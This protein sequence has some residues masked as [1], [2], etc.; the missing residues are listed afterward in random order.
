MAD[1]EIM[2]RQRILSALI[3]LPAFVLLVQLGSLFHFTLLVGLAIALGAWEFARLC[4]VGTDRG[5]AALSVLGALAWYA[6]TLWT[7][8]LAGLLALL[9]GVGLLRTL[10]IRAEIRVGVL[11]AAW[12][13]LGVAYVGGLLSFASLLRG[14]TDGRQLVTYLAF[15]IWAGD[16]GA[17]Y[18]GSRL[19]RRLLCPRISPKKTVEGAIGGI[20]A[21]VLLAI[22]GSPW[23][24]P[25]L[26]WG[27]AAE[28]GFV[29]AL[30]GMAG[31]LCE[32]AVKRG[33]AAK[34]SG[35]IIPGH[36]GVLDRL[37]SLMFAGPALY[38]L[39]WI[40]WV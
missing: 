21:T 30:V 34:D 22:L 19:G 23:I 37:D 24:W 33:A 9:A 14:L 36:G 11:Q 28:I 32:S 5:L 40:G 1:D 17:F 8:N 3:L 25:R 39:I 35:A 26:P 7:G 18:V 20:M 2:H 29:L 27:R 31:D 13:V 10:V 16:S 12:L 4:P 15:T 6:A 38:A